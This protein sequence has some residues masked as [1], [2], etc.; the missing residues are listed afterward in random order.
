MP[1]AAMSSGLQRRLLL[2]LLIPL[3]LLASVNTWFDYRSADDAALQQDRQLLKLVPL[4]ADSVVAP[5]SQ[6]EDPP[7]LLTAPAVEEFLKDHAGFSAFAVASLNGRVLLGDPWLSAAP[8]TT[9]EPEFLSEEEGGVTY[10]I[11]SQRVH[12]GAGELVVRLADG[13][14]PRQQWVRGLFFKVLL[15]NVVLMVVAVFVVNWGVRRALRPLL[16]L[17][18]AVEH[19]ASRDLSPIDVEAS[20]EEVRPLVQSLNRLFDLV[21][22]QAES[23]RRFVADAAHQ[24]RTPLAGLQA[25]VEA[26][27]Q[28]VNTTAGH[29]EHL[30]FMEKRPLVQAGHAQAAIILGA[31]QVNH[32][33]DA[34]RRT[35]QLANQLLA[36]SR[37]DARSL[38]AQ[39]LQ[40]VDL[41]A[42]CESLLE[43]HLDAASAK[44]I[45]L[46]LD[47]QA[48]QVTGHEWL[49]R[50]LLG[51][52]VDNALKYTPT[53]GT[54]T[55]R[56]AHT[57]DD[58]LPFL[59]VEDDGPGVPPQERVR[60]LQRFYRVPGTQGEGNGLGLAIAEEIARVHRSQL[61]VDS[62][63]D[64]KGTRIRLIF[65][66]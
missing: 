10:R 61:N 58:G 11:V 38:D 66:A 50:E 33:R 54:V 28:A 43:Q 63:R 29:E 21:N 5:G 22:A 57:P 60:V 15:P 20:P 4:M 2:L 17:R 35:S 41:K 47:A 19:R 37:A 23:Q 46:G 26:W 55:L 65:P 36:L 53:G 13:S 44:H 34:V 56:C 39:P 48:V 31:D 30:K 14:D 1:L 16:T 7:V 6:P 40:L 42:L 24:L 27:A 51:N 3:F 9:R 25:Q 62:G 12:T 49:L 8:P 52:L 59:E 64:N 45:D 32:M 18:E